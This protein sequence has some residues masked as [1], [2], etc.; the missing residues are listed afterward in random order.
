[1]TAGAPRIAVA[2]QIAHMVD[3]TIGAGR[4]AAMTAVDT[5]TTGAV[6]R[7]VRTT[8]AVGIG[9]RW[10]TATTG[11]A[12]R[13]LTPESGVAMLAT[14]ITGEATAGLTKAG[15][16]SQPTLVVV[17]REDQKVITIAV[18]MAAAAET[19]ISSSRS[20]SARET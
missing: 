3:L 16:A 14:M 9:G 13:A 1:M 10:V 6:R 2:Q 11:V 17:G 12:A 5:T 8:P 18:A 19:V 7:M 20:S 15:E 4:L